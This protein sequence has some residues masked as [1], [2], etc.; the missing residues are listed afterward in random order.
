MGVAFSCPINGRARKRPIECNQVLQTGARESERRPLILIGYSFGGIIVK[1]AMLLN[2]QPAETVVNPQLLGCIFLGTP[3]RGSAFSTAGIVRSL[4]THWSGSS[5]LQLKQLE[6]G[7]SSLLNLQKEF[8]RTFQAHGDRII[9][10]RETDHEYLLLGLRLPQVVTRDNSDLGIGREV[11]I[12]ES[13]RELRRVTHDRHPTYQKLLSCIKDLAKQFQQPP[14]KLK[15]ESAFGLDEKHQHDLLN[16]LPCATGAV[17]NHKAQSHQ[18][19]EEGTRVELLKKMQG[20][21]EDPE[22][23]RGFWIQGMAGTGKSTVAL[24]MASKLAK[25]GF[26]VGSFF[27]R[28]GEGDR[29][30]VSRL[31]PT[32]ARQ[33]SERPEFRPLIADALH[34]HHGYQELNLPSQWETLVRKPISTNEVAKQIPIVL[35]IDAIDECVRNRFGRHDVVDF[36]SGEDNFKGLKLRIIATSRPQFQPHTQQTRH[37]SMAL[38]DHHTFALHNIEE[39]MVK[40][41]I[42]LFFKANFQRL[43]AD[44]R[45]PKSFPREQHIRALTSKASPLFIAAM[46]SYLF[47]KRNPFDPEKQFKLL[48]DQRPGVQGSTTITENLDTMYLL[49]IE[50]ALFDGQDPRDRTVFSSDETAERFQAFQN[51][52]G[53]LIVLQEGLS[54]HNLA[55]LMSAVPDVVHGFLMRFTAVLEAPDLPHTVKLFHQ[56]FR[57]F[58]VDKERVETACR[59]LSEQ[60]GLGHLDIWVDEPSCHGKL[61]EYCLSTMEGTESAR[62][63]EHVAFLKEDI[64]N[65][66]TPDCRVEAVDVEHLNNGIPRYLEYACR[67]WVRHF[68]ESDQ[69]RYG[70]RVLRFLKQNVLYW[71]EAM[72]WLG[73]AA[74]VINLFDVLEMAVS[75]LDCPERTDLKTLVAEIRMLARRTR[76]LIEHA[77]LQLYSSGL[78]FS[79]RQLLDLLCPKVDDRW[80]NLIKCST[81]S[82]GDLS[83]CLLAFED[84]QGYV[85][86][87]KFSECESFIVSMDFS[88][89]ILVWDSQNGATL[90]TLCGTFADDSSPCFDLSRTDLIAF[91]GR[92]SDLGLKIWDVRQSSFLPSLPESEEISGAPVFS[93]DG[94]M[95][96]LFHA[97]AEIRMWKVQSSS[98]VRKFGARAGKQ[99]WGFSF[100]PSSRFLAVWYSGGMIVEIYDSE[101]GWSLYDSFNAPM[102][103]PT[104]NGRRDFELWW[105]HDLVICARRGPSSWDPWD[106]VC[107]NVTDASLVQLPTGSSYALP[108]ILHMPDLAGYFALNQTGNELRIEPLRDVG[109]QQLSFESFEDSAD[110]S[111]VVANRDGHLLVG[112]GTRQDTITVWDVQTGKVRQRLWHHSAASGVMGSPQLVLSPSGKLLATIDRKAVLWDTTIESGN[113]QP[114]PAYMFVEA[115][116]PECGLVLCDT[117]RQDTLALCDTETLTPKAHLLLPTRMTS[118]EGVEVSPSELYLAVLYY[119][120]SDRRLS[121]DLV[122]YTSPRSD[123][124]QTVNAVFS[125]D[126]VKNFTF[127][128]HDKLCAYTRRPKNYYWLEVVDLSTGQKLIR[129]KLSDFL[130]VF[131]IALSGTTLETAVCAIAGRVEIGENYE[132]PDGSN[133][134]GSGASRNLFDDA[135]M[136]DS[137]AWSVDDADMDDSD[138]WSDS[139]S[140]L[141]GPGLVILKFEQKSATPRRVLRY[142]QIDPERY[143]WVAFSPTGRTLISIHKNSWARRAPVLR[144]WDA[145]TWLPITSVDTE[146]RIQGMLSKMS[147]CREGRC[148]ILDTGVHLLRTDDWRLFRC[149]CGNI[150][151]CW[152]QDS[153][154]WLMWAGRRFFWLPPE[155]RALPTLLVAKNTVIIHHWYRPPL[156]ITFDRDQVEK[157]LGF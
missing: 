10:C 97:V 71:I 153:P 156:S 108:F 140:P 91:R 148:L 62:R 112:L 98:L 25:Q 94:Q 60:S 46:T 51:H 151:V 27:F 93:P 146:P 59:R 5:P 120:R 81:V 16:R 84:H 65:L 28:R 21:A 104:H 125:Q 50:E 96:A 47:I 70:S 105:V 72:G 48:M 145:R 110:I 76:S 122:V 3:H 126:D 54:Y 114:D 80:P 113:V 127:S 99:A 103:L 141:L 14:V 34:Q 73:N 52:L 53:S 32:I 45:F 87:L 152:L 130:D 56:S 64:L 42:E 111:Y 143:S 144:I 131:E 142:S 13:H 8:R 124:L 43:Q 15:V 82:E 83:P 75:Q 138:A 36:L 61:L 66:K 23:E 37:G 4:F 154:E 95:I 68:L 58:L 12:D 29:A 90:A 38:V 129:H 78:L 79:P 117:R 19:C 31:I 9:N 77:P 157:A 6:E 30:N 74:E 26:V 33:L 88:G 115:L 134:S 18:E 69:S 135:D 63:G 85:S 17:H 118:R 7:S 155:Y 11:F 67:Y 121:R 35:I 1:K 92:E 133:G 20:W 39:S 57:D 147:I 44:M 150:P 86:K 123:D 149:G 100:S 55:V 119:P 109:G 139:T 136:D 41:D 2:S 49:V 116:A 137:D 107:W 101:D 89:N 40:A 106:S 102:D 22:A 132:D 128:A 24:T